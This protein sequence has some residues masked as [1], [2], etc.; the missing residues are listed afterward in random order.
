MLRIGSV[1]GA[2]E[3]QAALTA[4]VSMRFSAEWIPP[5]TDMFAPLLC[6]YQKY[7]SISRIYE[8]ASTA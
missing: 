4:F 1:L 5:A 8:E 3:T 2:L 6:L 7:I